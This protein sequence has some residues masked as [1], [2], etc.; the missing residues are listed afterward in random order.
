MKILTIRY[1]QR[2]D[3]THA[4]AVCD[5]AATLAGEMINIMVAADKNPGELLPYRL[6]VS[7]N[8]SY[9]PG[10]QSALKHDCRT[11]AVTCAERLVTFLQRDSIRPVGMMHRLS[12]LTR[13]VANAGQAEEDLRNNSTVS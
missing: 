8:N 9:L 13:A 7:A 12:D 11:E 2:K 5:A 4:A 1:Y 3:A 6:D 10:L